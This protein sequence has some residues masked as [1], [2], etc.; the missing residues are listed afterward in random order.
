MKVIDVSCAACGE[1]FDTSGWVNHHEEWSDLHGADMPYHE[2]CCPACVELLP[3]DDIMLG[4]MV[5]Q[6]IP[7]E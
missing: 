6:V 4:T 7:Y 5:D 2:D 1:Q 3:M